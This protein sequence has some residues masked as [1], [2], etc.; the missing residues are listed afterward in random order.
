MTMAGERAR[1]PLGDLIEKVMTIEPKEGS[2]LL[3]KVDYM[4]D[5]VRGQIPDSVV[6][7]VS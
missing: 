2:A 7:P 6:I 5:G 3:F 4:K 1:Q